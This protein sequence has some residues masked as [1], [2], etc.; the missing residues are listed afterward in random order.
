MSKTI[1]AQGKTTVISSEMPTTLNSESFKLSFSSPGPSFGQEFLNS[2]EP[3]IQPRETNCTI[4]NCIA[5]TFDDGPNHQY[6]PHI[7]DLFRQY[8]ARASFFVIGS[9]AQFH[10]DLIRRMYREGHDIGNHTWSHPM[11]DRISPDQILHEFNATQQAIIQTGVPAPLLFRPPYGIRT[12]V[13]MS[14]VPLPQILW[15]VDPKDWQQ[16][17][18]NVIAQHVITHSQTGSVIVMHDTSYSTVEAMKLALPE[19]Q[20][21]FTL[22]TVRDMF[23]MTRESRGQYFSLQ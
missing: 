17:D 16:K 3:Y 18:P 1:Y 11:L 9:R 15:N 8:D 7:L 10:P 23:D 13:A 12:Q 19:L 20:K 5:I 2:K 14:L 22:V 4:E 6:T 21:R